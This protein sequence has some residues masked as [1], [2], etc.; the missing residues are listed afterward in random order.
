MSTARAKQVT[1]D[2]EASRRHGASYLLLLNKLTNDPELSGLREKH[3]AGNFSPCCGLAGPVWLL[4]CS[5]RCWWKATGRGSDELGCG[6]APPGLAVVVMMPWVGAQ[7]GL[8]L[9][10]LS[11]LPPPRR[12]STWS[13][14]TGEAGSGDS[15]AL[16]D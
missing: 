4:V 2:I 3:S 8:H 14:D 10:Q 12:S 1:E 13:G 7:P 9:C 11:C 6:D 15:G 5:V 16:R